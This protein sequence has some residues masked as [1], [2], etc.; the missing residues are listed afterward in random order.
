MTKQQGAVGIL[1]ITTL[2]LA[3][4]FAALAV[5]TGRLMM[6]K[7]RLQT[8]ADMAALDASVQAGHCG[9]GDLSKVQAL[10]YA[11]AVRNNHD[12]N[13]TQTLDVTLGTVSITAAGLRQFTETNAD[14][15]TAVQI[16][17]SKT[18]PASFFAGGIVGNYAHLSAS[19]VAERKALAGFVAGSSLLG[20]SQQ[21][22]TVM[23]LL[24]GDVLG[25][26]VNLTVLSYEG[27]A[28][29]NITLAELVKASTEIGN[30]EALLAS[31]LSL[32]DWLSLYANAVDASDVADVG[33][34]AA[35]QSLVTAN[36]NN[37]SA[38]FAEVVNVTTPT[39]EAA[40]EASI[41]LFDL[42]TTTALVAN[43][44]RAINLPLA[45]NLPGSLLNLSVQ[46][47]ITEAPHI[48][49]GPPGQHANGEWRTYMETAQLELNTLVQSTVNLNVLGLVGA[50]A[51]IDLALQMELAQSSAWLKSIQCAPF[52]SSETVVTIGVQPGAAM[53]NL[54]RATNGNAETASIDISATLPLL[55]RV[56][57]A[58]L[59]IGL[60]MPLQNPVSTDLIY[61]VDLRD[62]ND[63]P[64]SQSAAT[65][66]GLALS[67]VSQNI[68]VDVTLLGIISLPL[69]DQLIQEA[70]LGQILT[71]L[72]SQVGNSTVDPLLS[73]LGLEVGAMHLRL[74][75]VEV[76]RPDLKI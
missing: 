3:I 67:N 14:E 71:P 43:G 57:V 42:I 73:V 52:N 1:A 4:L 18:V 13:A 58:N 51:A 46:L 33:L 65:A 27:M 60:N 24:L 64:Q 47:N 17:A 8:V 19:A 21:Q 37:L 55:G 76:E 10:A 70:V 68:N 53:L 35:V 39:P 36:I 16:I 28:T 2:L 31:Q 56:P 34:S 12:V 29:T 59:G 62:T 66:P 49:I 30:T 41:N 7:R 40:A 38:S 75:T 11:S 72:L 61:Q 23:N 15:A 48:V 5:D 22:A 9:E 20:L 74:L 63:L 44:T 26:P 32:T 50:R 69:L 25:S 45:V 6:E 54:T